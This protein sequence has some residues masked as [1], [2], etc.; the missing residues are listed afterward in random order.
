MQN[1]KAL[2]RSKKLQPAVA[3]FLKKSC[4]VEQYDS[5]FDR[6]NEWEP[7]VV[8]APDTVTEAA[9]YFVHGHRERVG[10]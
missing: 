9:R 4:V 2:E 8:S 7:Y 6:C 5:E 3:V 10:I 1:V